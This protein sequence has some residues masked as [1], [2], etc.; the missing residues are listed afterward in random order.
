MK[1][2]LL[3]TDGKAGHENQSR[4]L[5]R[6]VGAEPEVVGIAFRNRFCKAL[7]YLFDHLGI[8][9]LAL[10]RIKPGA[11]EL[12]AGGYAA[13]IGTGSGCFYAAKTIARRLG[14]KCGVVLYPRGYRLDDFD[15]IL[16]PTFDR[17][18]TALNILQVPGNLVVS[19]AAFYED[20]AKEFLAKF[21]QCGGDGARVAVIIG[22][23][24]KCATMEADWMRRQLRRIFAENE[25]AQFWVTTSRR[26]P[27]AVNALL[28]EFDWDYKLCYSSDHYNPIPAFVKLATRIYVTAESTG[29]MSEVCTFGTAEVKAIDDLKPGRHKYRRYLECLRLE[30]FVDGARK[31]DMSL[32]F[33]RARHLLGL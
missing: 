19:D 1:K 18:S 30:N 15:V 7:S 26:T 5:A 23:P 24:N 25:G 12:A 11:K 33:D 2:V 6:A 20:K 8:R 9:T 3:L 21:P 14:V 16:A 28:G 29:M 31:I 32:E 17:P 4:A 22:G 13:V 10:Y 27:P